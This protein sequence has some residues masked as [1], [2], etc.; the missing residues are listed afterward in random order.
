[1]QD[2][3]VAFIICSNR[4]QD[5]AECL[6]YL[7]VLSVPASMEMEVLVVREATG[8]AAAYQFAMSQSNAKY[9][10]YLHQDAYLIYPCLIEKMVAI[11]K[12]NPSIG[13]MGVAGAADMPATGCWF[14]AKKQIGALIETSSGT[15]KSKST[16]GADFKDLFVPAD[17][18]DGVVMMTQYDVAWRA[19]LFDGWHFYD[20]SASYEFK[21]KGYGVAVPYQKSPWCIHRYGRGNIDHVYEHYRKIFVREYL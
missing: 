13:L 1:M 18:V 15:M 16:F 9:K 21:K 17:S 14:E 19:D 6:T 10:V 3:K 4:E 12:E 7:S 8:L 5:L 2:N 20:S 11:F